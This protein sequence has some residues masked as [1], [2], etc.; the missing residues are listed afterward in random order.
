MTITNSYLTLSEFK[1]FIT[2]PNVPLS[3]SATDDAVLEQ[4]I[5]GA[6]RFIDDETSRTFYPRVETRNFSVPHDNELE[7]DDDLLEVL[8]L[9]NGE[10]T[11]ISSTD[12]NLFPLNLEP[13][14]L[15][16]LTNS[17]GLFWQVDSQSD[18]I[19]VIP[20]SGLWGYHN[21]YTQRG[22]YNATTLGAA[23]D[24]TTDIFT[25]TS[26]VLFQADQ[27]IRIG[28]ELMIVEATSS[29]T[30]G[31]YVTVDKRGDNGSTAAAHDNASI[32]YIWRP[33]ADIRQAAMEISKNARDR[34]WGP[35]ESG[36]SSVSPAGVVVS[37]ADIT[38]TAYQTISRYRRKW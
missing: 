11:A 8:S 14:Y 5:E 15:L 12:Y 2:A 16:R 26:N 1:A 28:N 30:D 23:E 3:I 33:Q 38:K 20:L 18:S 21:R 31:Q 19:G 32:V 35:N 4:I 7:L 9:T 6:C 10:G 29:D 27:I 37:P 34:R 13:K 22:F 25:V 36:A 17:S 24:A